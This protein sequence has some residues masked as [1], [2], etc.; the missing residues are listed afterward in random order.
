MPGVPVDRQPRIPDAMAAAAPA[1]RGAGGLRRRSDTAM[2]FRP[3]CAYVALTQTKGREPR[4]GRRLVLRALRRRLRLSAEV[5]DA[6]Q[7]L[8]G[9]GTEGAPF[10]AARQEFCRR[11]HD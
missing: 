1:G 6:P 7:I 3:N 4:S 11:G 5:G 8:A 10:F 2:A 9:V